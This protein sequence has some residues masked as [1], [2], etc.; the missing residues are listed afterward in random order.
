MAIIRNYQQKYFAW[1][2]NRRR[3]SCDDK[4]TSVLSE[5]KVDLNPHQVD[6]ALFAFRSPLSM[7]TILTDE[8]FLV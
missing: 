3:N 5:T 4:F 2:L 7:G 1:Q 6:A 8:V